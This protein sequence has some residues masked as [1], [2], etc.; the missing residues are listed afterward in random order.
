ME[1]ISEML[2]HIAKEMKSAVENRKQM[3]RK[4]DATEI[5]LQLQTFCEKHRDLEDSKIVISY[6]KSSYITQSHK[7]K[8]VS[9]I[10]EPFVEL[11]PPHEYL[12]MKPLFTNIEADMMA[13]T[14]QLSQHF[15]Q[16]IPSEQEEV[17]RS[18][19]EILYIES[20]LFFERILSEMEIDIKEDPI[21]FGA[22]LGE[23]KWM[24]DL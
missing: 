17:R 24:G 5:K 7:F 10:E 4:I 15:F 1:Q 16:I 9:Y 18:Y 22:E 14:N 20:A 19:M 2:N 23:V 12:N 8:L 13:F 3:W 6:L 21:F 11:Y